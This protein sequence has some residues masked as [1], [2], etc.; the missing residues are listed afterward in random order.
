MLIL[1]PGIFYVWEFHIK[2]ARHLIDFSKSLN[3]APRISIYIQFTMRFLFSLILTLL[4]LTAMKGQTTAVAVVDS[5]EVRIGDQR[6]VTLELSLPLGFQIQTPAINQLSSESLEFVTQSPWDTLSITPRLRLRKQYIIQL[7]D[8]AGQ[9]VPPILF[10]VKH[11]SES[12]T[13]FSN[14]VLLK[15]SKEKIDGVLKDIKENELENWKLEDLW[16]WAFIPVLILLAGGA[17]WL[18]RKRPA[19]LQEPAATEPVL[20]P[21]DIALKKLAE[22][23]EKKLWQKGDIKGYHSELTHII[24]EYL[25]GR[26]QIKALEQTSD[27]ILAQLS[28]VGIGNEIHKKTKSLLQ[29]ADL[30]KFAKAEPEV[31]FHENA[32]TFAEGFIRETKP[33][34]YSTEETEEDHV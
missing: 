9:V 27:E 10:V 6:K 13:V 14:P 12:D 1:V 8:S 16:P 31:S 21:I 11:G 34:L 24:R 30:V 4:Y 18:L 3:L 26:Y 23:K 15:M 33:K 32:M 17:F 28:Q 7:W 20:S 22:L 29:T 25:E 2:P 19:K 5:V